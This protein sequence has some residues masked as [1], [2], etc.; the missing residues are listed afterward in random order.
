MAPE[1][2][3]LAKKW[4]ASAI[5]VLI[6]AVLLSKTS[7]MTD[8]FFALWM[9]TGVVVLYRAKMMEKEKLPSRL[10]K[11]LIVLGLSSCAM[12][13]VNIPLGIGRPPYS[14]DDFSL[15]VAGASLIALTLL[16]A[17]P[18][19]PP[20]VI[21]IVV[22][23]GYQVFGS[24]PSLWFKP[25]V[26]PTVALLTMFLHAVGLNPMVESNIMSYLTTKGEPVRIAIVADCTGI[27]SLIAYGVSVVMV[28]VL[29]PRIKSRGYL[30]IAAG[31]PI[32]YVLNLLRVT[33]IMLLVYHL[34]VSWLQTLHMHMGWVIFSAWM[35]VF[36]Y[37]FFSMRLYEKRKK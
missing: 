24:T 13:F 15:L 25:L 34:D 11:A 3:T 37:V 14:L 28:L 6:A 4:F 26:A 29:L 2:Y 9:M 18:L 22:V 8:L 10:K 17:S 5:A 35:I 32:T 36:W 21:P 33:L 27:G 7:Y 20:I 12:S 1:L 30:L 19:I 23:L 16:D 31:F